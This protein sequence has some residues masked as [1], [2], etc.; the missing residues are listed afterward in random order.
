MAGALPIPVGK[1]V[2]T[3][4]L[5]TDF[6]VT[7]L[8]LAG[9]SAE[10]IAAGEPDGQS[11]LAL[12]SGSAAPAEQRPLAWHYP[13]KWGPRGDRYEPF[14]ALRHGRWK[15]LYWYESREWELYDLDADLGETD[16]RFYVDTEVAAAM[17]ERLRAWM[18][19]TDAQRPIDKATGEMLPVP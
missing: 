18:R 13:H 16:N 2:P 19:E 3:P 6:Y 4:I 10:D 12:L 14:T 9:V 5:S 11:F 15:I 8:Q 17:Q 7:L 1:A